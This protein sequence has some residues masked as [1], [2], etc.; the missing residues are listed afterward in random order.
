MPLPL[1]ILVRHVGIL[2]KSMSTIV[3]CQIFKECLRKIKAFGFLRF[4][5]PNSNFSSVFH[6]HK[7]HRESRLADEATSRSV[8][9]G[10]ISADR[11]RF[12]SPDMHS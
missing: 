4:A 12:H 8:A 11:V 10:D 9:T 6:S 2:Y 7:V 3:K 1:Y 5:V